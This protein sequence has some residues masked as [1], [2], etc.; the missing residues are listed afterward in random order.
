[1]HI[2]VRHRHLVV[3]TNTVT[4]E[5]TDNAG[6][7]GTSTTTITVDQTNPVLTVNAAPTPVTNATTSQNITFSATDA[8][9]IAATAASS[10]LQRSPPALRHGRPARL[11]SA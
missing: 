4:V 3:G 10:A 6:N 5:A 8:N 2:A 1:M 7:V 11:L 9:G